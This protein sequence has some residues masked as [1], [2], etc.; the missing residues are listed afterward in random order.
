MITPL[1]DLWSEAVRRARLFW[2]TW[3]RAELPHTL[4]VTDPAMCEVVLAI[5]RLEKPQ[6]RE[7]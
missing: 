1:T 5:A 7:K 2:W 6:R 4:G 3:A